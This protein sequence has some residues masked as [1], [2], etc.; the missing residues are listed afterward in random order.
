MLD[1]RIIFGTQKRR[2]SPRTPSKHDAGRD[3]FPLDFEQY[4]IRQ[5]AAPSVTDDLRNGTEYP[6]K[7]ITPPVVS[8]TFDG[9]LEA[10]VTADDSNS[11]KPTVS[12]STSAG[13]TPKLA[14]Y[15]ILP[16]SSTHNTLRGCASL[17]NLYFAQVASVMEPVSFK[18]A[19]QIP[20][21]ATDLQGPL[22]PPQQQ[23]EYPLINA[24]T[25]NLSSVNQ[26]NNK[27]D[28]ASPPKK[29][30]TSPP[31]NV[32]VPPSASV[33]SFLLPSTL[34]QAVVSAI[35][36]SS[37]KAANPVQPT[38]F[39]AVPYK[40]KVLIQ[41][42]KSHRSKGRLRP[43][44]S[45]IALEIHHNGITY[46]QAGVLKFRQYVALAEKAGI[47]ELGGSGLTAWIALKAPWYDV[48]L[49]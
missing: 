40:F 49:S 7:V 13:S 16:S 43:L 34:S 10:P 19:M 30:D 17:P 9:S 4:D 45:P 39:P 24:Q 8:S 33:P 26:I 23:D 37:V 5:P 29:S 28:S 2:E 42:L 44:R 32:A 15:S 27:G 47:I 18:S 36:Q 31:P 38:S 48:P 6:A 22:L 20:P 25:Q 14:T 21:V 12:P 41:C 11:S 1:S 35:T 46:R 3:F